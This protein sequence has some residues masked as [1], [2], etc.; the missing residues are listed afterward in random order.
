MNNGTLSPTYIPSAAD[1]AGGSVVLTL[2]AYGN[3]PCDSVYD[4]MILTVT[5]A[6]AADAGNDD[7]VCEGQTFTFSAAN[8]TNFANIN[9]TSSGTG[10]FVNNG[11]ITPI[12]TPSAAD[13]AA[14]SVTI[15]LSAVG[16]SPCNNVTDDMILVISSAPVVNVGNDSIICQGDVYTFSGVSANNFTGL[17]WSTSGTGSFS[18]TGVLLPVYTPSAADISTGSVT[19]R[20]TTQGIVPCASDFDE[21]RLTICKLKLN[22]EPTKLL[23]YFYYSS[24]IF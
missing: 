23:I 24:I 14:G 12:Y 2:T 5:P 9:W 21:M 19:L 10:S 17:T 1:I 18:N 13:I 15:T 6:P 8:A 20:L 4:I 7:V 22:S 11:T 16:N 3:S